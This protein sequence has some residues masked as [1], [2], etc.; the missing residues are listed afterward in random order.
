M[1]EMKFDITIDSVDSV[2]ASQ[3]KFVAGEHSHA[4]FIVDEQTRDE[5]V[6]LIRGR[7]DE[8]AGHEVNLE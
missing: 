3:E 4:E 5:V 2:E 1:S 6:R 7:I 8:G